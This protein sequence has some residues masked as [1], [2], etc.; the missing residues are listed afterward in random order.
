MTQPHP[1]PHQQYPQQPQQP[2][3]GHPGPYQPAPPP[4][5]KGMPTG[6]IVAIV[7]GSVFGFVLL[8]GII[9]V[10]LDDTPS[11]AD[12][13]GSDTSAVAPEKRPAEKSD[14]RPAEKKDDSPA[15]SKSA[16]VKITAVKTTFAP[17]VLHS[18]GKYTSV[19]VKITNDSDQ[20][21]SVNPLYFGI[22]DTGGTK[23]SAEL[24]VDENQIDTVKLAPGEN[25]SG[26]ITGKGSF[27]PKYVTYTDGLFGD[28]VRAN[29]S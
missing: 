20:E 2:T 12:G 8:L 18:G 29:V 22:T 17:S 21:I 10:A 4:P 9:G 24:G 28:D 1:G 23:H 11:G 13:K 6:A 3:W 26:V 7:L 15:E 27:T 5:K 14:A 19:R 25:V 16:P